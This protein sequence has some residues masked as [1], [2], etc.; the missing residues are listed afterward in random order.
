MAKL[1]GQLC[2][3]LQMSACQGNIQPFQGDLD[4][5]GH[6]TSL[7]NKPQQKQPGQFSAPIPG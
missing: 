3:E 6:L 4:I 5:R 2:G 7:R 1:I